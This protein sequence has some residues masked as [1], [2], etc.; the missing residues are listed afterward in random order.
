M[1]KKIN[2]LYVYLSALLLCIL[3][4]VVVDLVSN[5][6][7]AD[8]LVK[9]S[10]E[11]LL[12]TSYRKAHFKLKSLEIKPL[13]K[14]TFVSTTG[15]NVKI[16]KEG[17][18]SFFQYRFK[19]PIWH[20][21]KE[22]H[23]YGYLEIYFQ[24]IPSF[25]ESVLIIFSA[26]LL[27]SLLI[28]IYRQRFFIILSRKETKFREQLSKEVAHDIRSPLTALEMMIGQMDEVSREK[29][30]NALQAIGRI[31]D[32]A[33]GLLQNKTIDEALMVPVR[34]IVENLLTEKRESLKKIKKKVDLRFEFDET[35]YGVFSDVPQILLKRVLSNLINNAAEALD[36]SG[37]INIRLEK[38]NENFKL[39]VSDNG[40]GIPENILNEINK[41]KKIT[42]GK[43]NGNGIGLVHAFET[44]ESYNGLLRV[45]SREG[46]GTSVVLTLP[47][48]TV[49][50]WFQKE[51]NIVSKNIILFDDDE[52]IHNSWKTILSEKNVNIYSAYK[53]EELVNLVNKIEDY[54]IISD[55][56]LG[57]DKTGLETLESLS[58]QDKAVLVTSFYNEKE[59][60]DKSVSMGMKIIPKEYFPHVPVKDLR[61]SE[62]VFVDDEML[63]R[64][65][66]ELEASTRG[67]S[68]KTY[69]SAYEVK[70]NIE[71]YNYETLFYIDKELAGEDGL[72]LCQW[73]SE[74]GY[75]HIHLATG[76]SPSDFRDIKYLS[77]VV[78]KEFPL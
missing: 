6:K 16:I 12:Y 66:W 58:I 64:K 24:I 2:A 33:N 52:S 25:F 10:R 46:E 53:K 13:K 74:K 9:I 21:K 68:C 45:D 18:S 76:H 55:Y 27:G 38:R 50:K 51:L 26:F 29:R 20:S 34:S 49:P 28:Y 40:K 19:R 56:D 39:I 32:I 43:I 71:N 65:G 44:M 8:L 62:I 22:A 59:V 47:L 73:L 67:L 36:L 60:Q 11:D 72:E 41:N 42:Y 35:S 1:M 31:Q 70:K 23:I 30:S 54:Q 57:E 78:G 77:G 75:N 63:L 3:A 69:S 14:V 17:K 5:K 4:Y 48:A 61:N 7:T 37:V 15:D